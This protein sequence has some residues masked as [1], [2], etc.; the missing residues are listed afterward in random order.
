MIKDKVQAALEA[1]LLC[2]YLY[3][4][5]ACEFANATIVETHLHAM[6]SVSE[7]VKFYKLI[8]AARRGRRKMIDDKVQAAL[9][10][11]LLCDYLFR[12]AA[13]QVVECEVIE[14]EL[15]DGLNETQKAEYNE[16]IEAARQAKK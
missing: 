13:R 8:W 12:T 3:H 14:K 16:W 10:S 15:F 6:L 7:R 2:D 5:K 1:A 4:A 9:A 11:S